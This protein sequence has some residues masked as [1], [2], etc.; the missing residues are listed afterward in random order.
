MALRERRGVAW[1]AG[2]CSGKDNA[3]VS[4]IVKL[5]EEV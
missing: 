3:L 5:R 4:A 2:R 1:I